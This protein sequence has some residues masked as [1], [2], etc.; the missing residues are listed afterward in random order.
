MYTI[1]L[2]TGMIAVIAIIA[3]LIYA[4]AEK[5]TWLIVIIGIIIV[6]A[7]GILILAKVNPKIENKIS[8]SNSTKTS[9]HNIKSTTFKLPADG[10]I[11]SRDQKGRT[12]SYKKGQ[13]VRFEQLTAPGRFT[14]INPKSPSFSTSRKILLSRASADGTITLMSCSGKNMNI[15]VTVK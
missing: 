1:L 3:L 9:S 2:A 10:T 5:K 11:V 15:K 12:I 7:I 13:H 6:I 4:F 14:Y 8:I